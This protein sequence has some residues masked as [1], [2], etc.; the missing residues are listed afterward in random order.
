MVSDCANGAE[1]ARM[2]TTLSEWTWLAKLIMLF[3]GSNCRLSAAFLA[4]NWH[5][6]MDKSATNCARIIGHEN[7][8]LRRISG[9]AL[10]DVQIV[11]Q[12]VGEI[13]SARVQAGVH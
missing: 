6:S 5:L 1:W 11:V 10:R 2:D 13:C 8:R 9:L 4:V 3:S 12:I 7:L